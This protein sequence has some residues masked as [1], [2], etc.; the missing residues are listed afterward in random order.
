MINSSSEV[1]SLSLAGQQMVQFFLL[2]HGLRLSF[3][4]SNLLVLVPRIN[5]E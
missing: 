3:S 5:V 1:E 4:L 2:F